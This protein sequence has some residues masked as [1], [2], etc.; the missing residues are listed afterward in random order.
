MKAIKCQLRKVSQNI[1]F[2]IFVF[3]K[4]KIHLVGAKNVALGFIINLLNNS[5]TTNTY[6]GGVWNHDTRFSSN[7]KIEENENSNKKSER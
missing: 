5:K 4:K 6:L 2:S 1:I 3:P 7:F